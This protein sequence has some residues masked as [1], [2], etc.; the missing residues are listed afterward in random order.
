MTLEPEMIPYISYAGVKL[1]AYTFWAYL[2][3]RLFAERTQHRISLSV[4]YGFARL[5]MGFLLGILIFVFA[6]EL[7]NSINN[8]WLT[9][10]AIYVP[11]RIVEWGIMFLIISRCYSK[12]KQAVLWIIGGIAISCLADIP[13]GIIAG[14]QFVPY[15][16]P[17]C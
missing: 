17:L 10:V 12:P 8:P 13:L 1:L 11:A 5:L 7:N 14:W 2:G 9:Y 15:G 6:L 3:V 16:R 4:L